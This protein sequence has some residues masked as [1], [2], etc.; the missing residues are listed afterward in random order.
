MRPQSH[1]PF[2]G[3]SMTLALTVLL[4]PPSTR[5][6]ETPDT[7]GIARVM[8]A[9]PSTTF[10]GRKITEDAVIGT[11]G[12]LRTGAD[13]GARLKL[14]ENQ[15]M[16]DVA[17]SSEIRIV[18]PKGGNPGETVELVNGMA[19][20]RVPPAKKAVEKS[21]ER[22]EKND[23]PIF[24]LRTKKGTMGVR[25]TDFLAIANSALD[26][27]EI[28]VFEGTVEFASVENPNDKKMIKDG[29]WGGIGGRFGKK[30]TTPIK[31]SPT[32]LEH[33]SNVSRTT[34]AYSVQ[35]RES[36]ETKPGQ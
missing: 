12:A 25:G 36:K 9:S 31:L 26:E 29:F 16:V 27:A 3:L 2:F 13:G 32:A 30:T 34:P 14:I 23:K 1:S 11:L 33:F 6:E 35:E 19:R 28:V 5:A 17:A 24:L 10:D 22:K 4:A 18:M 8:A 21:A 20:V 15:T 7:G